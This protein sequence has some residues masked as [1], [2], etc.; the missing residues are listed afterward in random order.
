MRAD[1]FFPTLSAERRIGASSEKMLNDSSSFVINQRNHWR[2]ECLMWREVTRLIH[3]MSLY[4]DEWGLL[5][6]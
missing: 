2:V 6:K 5:Q 1:F 4:W 3:L